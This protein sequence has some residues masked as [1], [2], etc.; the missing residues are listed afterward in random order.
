MR[1]A[2][3]CLVRL[4]VEM[5]KVAI[6]I[7]KREPGLNDTYV[8]PGFDAAKRTHTFL[9][10]HKLTCQTSS[11]HCANPVAPIGWPKINTVSKTQNYIP[12]NNRVQSYRPAFFPLI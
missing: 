8:I 10:Q 9:T 7:R 1:E 2:T 12:L 4:H 3:P 11:A 5:N 6:I